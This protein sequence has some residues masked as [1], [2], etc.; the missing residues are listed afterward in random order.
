[1]VGRDALVLKALALV[2]AGVLQI[3]PRC[4]HIKGDV[5]ATAAVRR[6]GPRSPRTASSCAPS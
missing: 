1:M 4:T 6:S 3:S 2:L 5:G